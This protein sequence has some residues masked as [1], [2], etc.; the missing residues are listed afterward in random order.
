[1]I[2]IDAAR[3][4]AGSAGS[5]TGQ[6]VK[7]Q[8]AAPPRKSSV[9]KRPIATKIYNLYSPFYDLLFGWIEEPRL[10]KGIEA[11]GIEPGDRVLDIGIGT[12]IALPLYPR[13]CQLIGI[14]ASPGMLEQARRK[15][16]RL[17]LDNVELLQGDALNLQFADN[18]FDRIF[19]SLVISVVADPVRMVRE[20]L[21]VAK[22]GAKIVIVNHFRAGGGFMRS[23]EGAMTP[24]TQRLGWRS[25]LSLDELV[26]ATGLELLDTFQVSRRDLWRVVVAQ[27]PR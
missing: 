12:G 26:Q 5:Y 14:D 11:L 18:S 10:R 24:V 21:R 9:D 25:D 8:A 6:A 7:G 23:F 19:S 15:V 22:P 20:I 16:R 13:D 2:E 1:M 27:K 17:K 3:D 4:E